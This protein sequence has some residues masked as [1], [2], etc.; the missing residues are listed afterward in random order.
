MNRTKIG[1]ITTTTALILLPILVFLG[2][3]LIGRYP[4]SPTD[5]LVAIVSVFVPIKTNLSSAIYT[6]VWNIRLP[7]I[8]AAMIVGAALSI[9]G[10]SFQGTFQNPLVS[11]D[12]LGVSAGAGFGAALA[13]LLSFSTV[14]I[15]V[16]AFI[17]GLVAVSLTYFLSKSFKGNTMLMMVLG[18][19]AIGSL[20]SALISC[21][22]YV[23]DPES[24]LPE[25]VYWLMG[26]LSTVDSSSVMMIII[27]VLIGFTVLLLLRWRLNVLSMGDE[28]A[29]SLGVDT[30]KLRIIV[31]LCCTLLTSAAV[32]ISGIIGW[33]GLVIPHIARMIVGPDHKKLLPASISIGA[34]FLLVVDD[35]CRTATSIEIPLGILTALIGAPF[36]IYL[37]KKG[38]EGWS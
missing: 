21:I 23:A 38:Y 12:I 24:K 2:S 34:V 4:V 22:K 18:G 37:L 20:F 19:I 31:I 33:V 25:I 10:A 36:F 5:V 11:P 1:S 3:F 35:V 17:F 29:R 26:S 6:V 15:Q 8:V 7:R 30:E 13:I 27:P 14:M 9:S 32:S 28:E 16:T